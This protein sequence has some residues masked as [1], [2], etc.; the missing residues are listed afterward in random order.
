MLGS[1]QTFCLIVIVAPTLVL[2]SASQVDVHL[3][4]G[5][6]LLEKGLYAQAAGEFE[7]A[8]KLDPKSFP[9]AY[10]LGFAYWNLRKL[11]LAT[12]AFLK[13]QRL[14]P[15]DASS[16]YY[17]GQIHLLKGET[18]QAIALFRQ[19]VEKQ[20]APVAD[21]HYQLGL[22]YLKKGRAEDAIHWLSKAAE[23]HPREAGIRTALGK[24]YQLAG[25]SEEAE[26]AF[27]ASAQMREQDLEASK[28][29]QS[30]RQYL[31]SKELEKALEIRTRLLALD[32]SEFLIALGTLFGENGLPDQ[33]VEPFQKALK[34]NENS[35]E[36]Q[37]NLG[38]TFLGLGKSELAEQ[39][40]GRAVQLKPDS[41]EACSLLGVAQTNRKQNLPAIESFRRAAELRPD[42]LRILSLLALQFI[43]GRYY[44]EAIRV[45]TRAIQLNKSDPDLRF[46]LIQAHYKNQ[47][48]IKALQLAQ[49]TL[50]QYPSLARA[51]YE[52]G[53]QLASMGRFEESKAPFKKALELQPDYPE[54]LYALGDLLVKEGNAEGALTYLMRTLQLNPNY[55]DASSSLG[56][57]LLELKRYDEVVAEMQK[58]I[59]QD[60]AEPQPHLHLAQAYRSLGEQEKAK[61]ELQ[62]FGQ[63]NK[64]R[65][66]R[67]D[68]QGVRKFPSE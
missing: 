56:R 68:Q 4:K 19:L 49:E 6:E 29:L 23:L 52:L 5:S 16:R 32:D 8:S 13:A 30:C 9:A 17:L 42:N 61:Q 65:M 18:D 24:A 64:E 58:A 11:E 50:Q 41:F 26:Q 60:P 2:S 14:N 57:A 10:N 31:Q 53:F 47:D 1:I 62:V 38:Y 55:A 63:L 21:E 22:A 34:L 20:G 37:F 48:S 39:H 43:E 45:L 36:A 51:H 44:E 33:A 7:D 54:A 27:K 25:R 66:K 35:F 67:K 15:S 3:L 40:L 46:L 59:S 28:L 12:G